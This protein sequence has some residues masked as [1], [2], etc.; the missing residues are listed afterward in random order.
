M[1]ICGRFVRDTA[2]YLKVCGEHFTPG[3]EVTIVLEYP[4]DSQ[5]L[6]PVTVDA[7]GQFEDGFTIDCGNVPIVIYASDQSHKTEAATL[8]DI[9]RDCT[10][11]PG[12]SWAW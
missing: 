3:D 8:T 10:P 5:S 4:N 9:P 2:M 6:A 7:K 11:A 12:D 1:V